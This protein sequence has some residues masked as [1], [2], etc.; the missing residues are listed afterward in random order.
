MSKSQKYIVTLEQFK[1][2]RPLIQS[3]QDLD[4]Y[5]QAALRKGVMRTGMRTV[6]DGTVISQQSAMGDVKNSHRGTEHCRAS[7]MQN[8]NDTE[9]FVSFS[10]DGTS[11]IYPSSLFVSLSAL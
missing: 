4:F 2:S 10:I 7:G 1:G 8:V 3:G 11:G 6:G 9:D 5:R